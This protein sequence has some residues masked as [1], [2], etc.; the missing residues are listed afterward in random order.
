MEPEGG[1]VQHLAGPYNRLHRAHLSELALLINVLNIR[2]VDRGVSK[3]GVPG[4]RDDTQ[5]RARFGRVQNISL[6]ALE[7]G[8][9]IPSCH[10]TDMGM[11]MGIPADSEMKKGKDR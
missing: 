9:H 3:G 4:V 6:G 8:H 1:D 2:P 11:D 10:D 7:H 5:Q